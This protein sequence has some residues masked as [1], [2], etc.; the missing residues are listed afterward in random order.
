M[1]MRS[2]PHRKPPLPP[3]ATLEVP[4]NYSGMFRENFIGQ[5][6]NEAERAGSERVYIEQPEPVIPERT[7][8][9]LPVEVAVKKPD[10]GIGGLLSGLFGGGI[11]G[12]EG[13]EL[14]DIILLAVIFFLLK[15]GIEDD[16]VLILGLILLSN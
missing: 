15:D 1:Y 16:L 4:A 13:I 5:R 9:D 2:N 8:R 6:E 11:G 14:E 7:A 12:K 3:I 10:K